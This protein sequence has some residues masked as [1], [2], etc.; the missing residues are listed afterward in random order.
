MSDVLAALA[1]PFDPALVSWR[2]GSTSKDK[3]KAKALAYLDARDVMRR[4]DEVCGPHWQCRYLPMPNGT[5]CCEIGIRIDQEWIFRA[6]GAG[7]TDIE[8][9][10]GGYSD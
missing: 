3:T 4:L 6:N 10:K 8:G 1:A 5:T 9:E 2:P 7:N